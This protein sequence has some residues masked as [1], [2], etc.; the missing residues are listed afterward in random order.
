VR[1][2]P[3]GTW[4]RRRAD[5]YAA[6]ED[7]IGPPD[8]SERAAIEHLV[9][10]YLAGFGPASAKDVASFTGLT[11]AAL[12]PVLAALELRRFRSEPAHGGQQ[13]LVVWAAVEV[14]DFNEPRE[15]LAIG[16][17]SAGL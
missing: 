16:E 15:F 8:V 14:E 6:A 4:E 13:P 3:S 7:W 5:L 1:V 11:P 9:R 2:P 17:R 12:K 10:R